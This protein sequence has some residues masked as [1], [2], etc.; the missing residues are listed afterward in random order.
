M[1]VLGFVLVCFF[2]MTELIKKYKKNANSYKYA[3]LALSQH[4][5]V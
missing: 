4:F 1:C 2:M 3:K 5:G